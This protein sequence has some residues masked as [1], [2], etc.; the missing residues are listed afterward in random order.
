MNI[1]DFMD[2]VNYRI[3][4]G[5]E[6]CWNCF[7]P[8]A[9]RLDS[10][11]GLVDGYTISIVFDTQTQAVYQV[12]ACD[13]GHNRA[14][15]WTNPM[16]KAAHDAEALQR[17][18]NGQQA[19]DDVNFVELEVEQDFLDKARAIVQGTEYDTRVH[20]EIDWPDE[21]LNAAMRLAHERDIT[22]NQL[23]EQCLR[24]YLDARAKTEE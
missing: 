20:I 11:N 5:S 1:K 8:N 3:T 17:N 4:E 2:V 10:W 22:L 6:F 23:V 16:V 13:Y 9:H 7:G 19:W 12:E 24:D 14:Y 21:L 18:V 15:R